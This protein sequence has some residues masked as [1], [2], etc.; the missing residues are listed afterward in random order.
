[1]AERKILF[2]VVQESDNTLAIEWHS[3]LYPVLDEILPNG[4]MTD[5]IIDIAEEILEAEKAVRMG[6]RPNKPP[7]HYRKLPTPAMRFCKA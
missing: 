4:E 6:K 3:D 2:S 7:M 5:R 1:M